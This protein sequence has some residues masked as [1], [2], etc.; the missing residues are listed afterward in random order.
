MEQIIEKDLQ[1]SRSKQSR[2]MYKLSDLIMYKKNNEI[3][4][5]ALEL[6]NSD[7]NDEFL[8]KH[9][10][11]MLLRSNLVEIAKSLIPILI[12]NNPDDPVLISQQVKILKKSGLINKG[13]KILEQAVK[14]Y[15]SDGYLVDQY[16]DLLMI[17][18]HKK[19]SEEIV[20]KFNK[21]YPGNE[22]LILREAKFEEDKINK[23]LKLMKIEQEIGILYYMNKDVKEVMPKIYNYI[24]NNDCDI[25]VLEIFIINFLEIGHTDLARIL[26][27]FAIENT[28][29][30]LEEL[31][32]LNEIIKNIPDRKN[33]DVLTK[34]K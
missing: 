16:I 31:H 3:L 34:N 6:L 28:N 23:Q 24:L 21:D 14:K 27:G 4:P 29:I 26:C 12:K 25:H 30:S 13:I 18:G 33:Y 1:I 17:R 20:R 5:F 22:F 10:I 8:N 19:M 7:K 11:N 32:K 15:P 2:N 9:F